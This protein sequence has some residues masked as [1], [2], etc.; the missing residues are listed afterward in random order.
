[1]TSF[2]NDFKEYALLAILLSISLILIPLNNKPQVKNLRTF[3]FGTF[4]FV[5]E[6]FSDLQSFFSTENQLEKTRKLNA[7]LMLRLNLLREYGIENIQLKKMLGYTEKSKLQLVPAKIVS[8]LLLLGQ[9]NII[10]NKGSNDGLSEAMPLVDEFGLAGFLITVSKNFSLARTIQNPLVKI[11][12]TDQRSR[13]NGILE[14]NGK[15][16]LI[17]NLPSSA[18]FEVGDRIIT[19][20]FSTIFPPSIP[21][22]VV[23]KKENSPSGL[24]SSVTVKP[25]TR[26][27]KENFVFVVKFVNNAQLDSLKLNLFR[28]D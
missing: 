25:F 28:K 11:S 22:G 23:V 4:A 26:I 17:R 14:W 12:V 20:E 3:A 16:F 24:L 21:V 1:L 8:R 27:N 19:S 10:I 2:F 15:N 18:D 9:G 7:E 6:I 5:D 13:I